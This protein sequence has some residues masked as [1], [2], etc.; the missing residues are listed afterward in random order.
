MSD[1][2]D[3]PTKAPHSN[4][5]F[6]FADKHFVNVINLDAVRLQHQKESSN[7]LVVRMARALLSTYAVSPDLSLAAVLGYDPTMNNQ[8]ALCRFI[9][10]Q[11]RLV[12]Q[13]L[14]H[15]IFNVMCDRFQHL[16][17]RL[18]AHLHGGL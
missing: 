7:R 14:A 16:L 1:Y 3:E 2:I 11:M 9:K 8:D 17:T 12:D 10:E 18:P 13:P 4:R 6:P 5:T 15:A